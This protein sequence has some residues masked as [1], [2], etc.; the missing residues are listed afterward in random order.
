MCLRTCSSSACSQSPG[1]DRRSRIARTGGYSM[2]AARACSTSGSLI[3]RA[4]RSRNAKKRT[5]GLSSWRS[6][7]SRLAIISLFFPLAQ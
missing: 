7:G 2:I 4:R 3:G 6:H 1:V 5:G